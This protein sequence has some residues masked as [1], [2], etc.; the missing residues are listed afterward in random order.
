MLTLFLFYVLRREYEIA[1][2]VSF[3]LSSCSCM[4][5]GSA[6]KTRCAGKLG[7]E[8]WPAIDSADGG[9]QPLTGAH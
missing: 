5:D 6:D 3:S 1:Q 9:A 7:D 4:M 8:Q 2:L